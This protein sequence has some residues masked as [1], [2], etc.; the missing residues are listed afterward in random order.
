MTARALLLLM[1]LAVP[2]RAESGLLTIPPG[3]GPVLVEFKLHVIDLNYIR[4][5]EQSFSLVGEYQTYWQDARLAFQ[6]GPGEE[7]ER[8]YAAGEVWSPQIRFSN[9]QD[10]VVHNDSGMVV[11]PDGRVRRAVKFRA[12]ANSPFNFRAFPFD[13]TRL[14]LFVEPATFSSHRVRLKSA[15]AGMDPVLLFDGEWDIEQIRCRPTDRSLEYGIEI[16]R[17]VGF[18]LWSF[19]LPLTL[20]TVT[21]WMQYWSMPPNLQVTSTAIVG[22]VAYKFTLANI[23]PRI[24][25]LSYADGFFLFCLFWIFTTHALTTRVLFLHEQGHDQRKERLRIFGRWFFVAGF[26]VG[27]ALI[28][29]I[30]LT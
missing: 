27:N 20:I 3:S 30:F 6:P 14:R 13:R 17:R 26:L 4:T 24:N 22:L 25:Y 28:A 18:Y 15:G 8:R 19:F 21:S 23:L 1:L 10:V 16:R 5:S 2:A 29:W 12:A 11:E 9:A 7:R